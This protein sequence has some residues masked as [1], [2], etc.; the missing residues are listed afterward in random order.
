MLTSPELDNV[1]STVVQVR[2]DAAA[3]CVENFAM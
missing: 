3:S 2:A 1:Y